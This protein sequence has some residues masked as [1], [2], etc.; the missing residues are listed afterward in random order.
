MSKVAY[1]P[2]AYIAA[3]TVVTPRRVVCWQSSD[4]CID[5]QDNRWFQT[6]LRHQ[7]DFL[8]VGSHIADAKNHTTPKTNI[9]A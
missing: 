9:S 7:T 1:Q 3:A 8:E 4:K 2:A 6:I 5:M